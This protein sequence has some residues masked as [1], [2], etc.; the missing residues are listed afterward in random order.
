MTIVLVLGA[1]A[2]WLGH[3]RWS[4]AERHRSHEQLDPVASTN[5]VSNP[6]YGQIGTARQPAA[7][8]VYSA[9]ADREASSPPAGSGASAYSALSPTY[10]AASSRP[11]P[12]PASGS[13]S[14]DQ[15]DHLAAE[16]R[17]AVYAVPGAL[18][19][20]GPRGQAVYDDAYAPPDDSGAAAVPHQHGTP[21]RP[22]SNNTNDT[23]SGLRLSPMHQ[24]V[25]GGAGA[26][27]GGAGGGS[28]AVEY[29]VADNGASTSTS[30]PTRT[31]S[32][33]AGAATAMDTKS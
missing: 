12:R 25:D 28:R 11:P 22:P 24:S 4:N 18:T 26:G 14:P 19:A 10:G 7:D 1:A 29:A 17:V 27:S 20:A 6:V 5:M 30:A 13:S 9:L 23:G 21:A 3:R 33:V 2:A 8:A 15:Y 32:F 16:P 31:L